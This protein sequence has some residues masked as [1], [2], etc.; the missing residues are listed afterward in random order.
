MAALAKARNTKSKGEPGRLQ[1]YK[2]NGGSKIYA[3]AMVCVD[4]QGYARPAANTADF[5]V[6]GRAEALADNTDGSDGDISVN[7]LEGV[8]LWGNKGGDLVDQAMVG[9]VCYV[10]DDQTVCKT[11]GNG[12][13]VGVVKEIATDGVWVETTTGLMGAGAAT[14]AAGGSL[15][16]TYPNPT[17]AAG[18]LSSD[19][20]G[21]AMMAA[22]YFNEATVDD[23]FAAGS[24]DG[25]RLK[26]AGVT[27]LQLSE[28][29]AGAPQELSGA[30]AV[31]VTARTTLFASTGGAEALTLA[32]GAVGQRKT[33]IHHVDGGSGVLT[34]T[35]ANGFST[36]TFTNVRDWVELE[37]K[38]TDGWTIVAIGGATVA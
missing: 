21:R 22:S 1:S 19:V 25:D 28:T 33:I 4:A 32:D 37:W 12:V 34:P 18:A 36:I 6:V 10:E 31:N 29:V 23:K 14:G 9:E 5:K 20:T 13:V 8:Y 15:S 35:T 26:T 24:I 7:V 11:A 2:V 16:G 30:G 27:E 3:G 38:A 17:I